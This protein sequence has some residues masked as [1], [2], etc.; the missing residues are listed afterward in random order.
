[1]RV[2]RSLALALSPLLRIDQ[3]ASI[4][5]DLTVG[6]FAPLR[7][8]GASAL[9]TRH[10]A[11]RVAIAAAGLVRASAAAVVVVVVVVA[12]MQGLGARVQTLVGLVTMSAV[13]P[14][15]A[16]LGG[17]QAVV[18]DGR[19]A[20]DAAGDIARQLCHE[21][22]V[23][24]THYRDG[25]LA[26]E[27]LM[28]AYHGTGEIQQVFCATMN[29]APRV[30]R[31]SAAPGD[32]VQ[33]G[34]KRLTVKRCSAMLA[35]LTQNWWFSVGCRPEVVSTHFATCDKMAST[36]AGRGETG[37]GPSSSMDG[38]GSEPTAAGGGSGCGCGCGCD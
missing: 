11:I 3:A 9:P 24:V 30:S 2:I 20:A 35:S 1:M 23:P 31:L 16:L 8:V 7:G 5:Q 10:G 37:A 29:L 38:S 15:L 6:T 28:I 33:A 26:H 32:Q 27:R 12:V 14:G 21:E 34:L 13:G 4:T 19:Y 25:P 18:P 22:D 36:A 17:P